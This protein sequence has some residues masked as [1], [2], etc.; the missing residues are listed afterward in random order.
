MALNDLLDKIKTKDLT[1]VYLFCGDEEYT[2]DFYIRKIR[3]HCIASFPPDSCRTVFDRGSLTPDALSDTVFTPPFMGERKII[4]INAFQLTQPAPLLT[5]YVNIL[6]NIPKGISVLFVYRSGEFDTDLLE[7]K[8]DG[9]NE[10]VNFIVNE[11]IHVH[12]THEKGNKLVLWIQKHFKSENAEISDE[13]ARFLIE[14]CG[15]DMYILAGEIDKLCSVYTSKPISA[16]DI[17]AVCC[18]NAEYRLYDIVNSLAD[19]N[20]TKIKKIYEA[21]IFAKVKPELIL[22]TISGYFTDLH[23]FRTAFAENKT[24]RELKSKL[25][26]SDFQAGR[27]ASAARALSGQFIANGIRECRDTDISVKRR[28]SDSYTAIELMLYRI[29]AYGKSKN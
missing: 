13:A 8:N 24:E 4:E 14:Y 20:A 6:G 10:F 12:F 22:G 3:S 7:G 1:G 5:R 25:G 29:M 11:C 2:K 9:K 19:G 23:N 17:E 16:A 21:L 28:A 15:N 26:Y 27:L 18:A